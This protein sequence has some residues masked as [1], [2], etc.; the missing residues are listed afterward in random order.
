MIGT[1]IASLRKRNNL[2]Q[3]EV[4]EQ[5]NV[6]RQTLAKWERGEGDPDMRSCTILAKMFDV[7]LDD[8]VNYE[9]TGEEDDM[10]IGPKGKYFFGAVTVG[11]RGQIV[12]PQKAR[13]VFDIKAGDQLLIFGDEERGLAIMPKRGIMGIMSVLFGN[14]GKDTEE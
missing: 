7:T 12:I 3:E 2:T 8:L 11:E 6:S 1:N 10:G 14:K 5:L 9:A 13:K 4:A